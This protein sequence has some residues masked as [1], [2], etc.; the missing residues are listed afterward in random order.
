MGNSKSVLKDDYYNHLETNGKIEKEY[1]KLGPYQTTSFTF[2]KSNIEK[3]KQFIVCCPNTFDKKLPLVIFVN[4]TGIIGSRYLPLFHHL[5]SYGF[6]VAG[7][8]DEMSGYG[9]STSD[10][11]DFM[12][13][14]NKEKGL[15]YDK[16]DENNIGVAGHSQGGA[17]VLNAVSKFPNSKYYKCLFIASCMPNIKVDDGSDAYDTSL[18]HIPYFSITSNGFFDNKISNKE[19]LKTNFDKI[20]DNVPALAAIRKKIDHGDTLSN[21]D[22]YMTA[23]FS[24]FLKG[25]L[26]T[27]DAFFGDN[28]E[29]CN[30]SLW[31]DIMR[32]NL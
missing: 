25:D 30:N 11:L 24:Y 20:P 14:L 7:N 17:G 21:G 1:T 22:G 23:W 27:K 29:I 6:I 10:T 9:H 15:F 16:I 5:A 31:E 4:G 8:D 3:L 26:N 13:K 2:F 28:P 12:L 18:I 32:K 19:L